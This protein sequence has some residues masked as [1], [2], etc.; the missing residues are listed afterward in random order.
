MNFEKKISQQNTFL[1][2]LLKSKNEQEKRLLLNTS[3]VA[4]LRLLFTIINK[5]LTKKL[6]FDITRKDKQKLEPH[7]SDLLN[8]IERSSVLR[9]AKK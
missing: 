8:F 6:N 7:K 1:Q 3:T 9:Q 2:T 4:Q 5:G